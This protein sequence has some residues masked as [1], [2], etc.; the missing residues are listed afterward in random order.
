[1]ANCDHCGKE[2]YVGDGVW[3][4]DT[5]VCG[6]CIRKYVDEAEDTE[7]K[8]SSG[9]PLPHAPPQSKPTRR[10]RASARRA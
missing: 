3:D 6:N 1:M 8:S 9:K 4:D 10:A 5:Y 2:F 7:Q